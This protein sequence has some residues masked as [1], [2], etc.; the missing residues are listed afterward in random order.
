MPVIAFA[1]TKGGV[2]KTTGAINVAC[3]LHRR[4]MRTLLVDC[5]HT[6][7]GTSTFGAFAAHQSR[8]VPTVTSAPHVRYVPKMSAD[9]EWTVVDVR[10]AVKE[11]TGELDDKLFSTTLWVADFVVVSVLPS[12]IDVSN[13]TPTLQLMRRAQVAKPSLQIGVFLNTYDNTCE[14]EHAEQWL[15]EELSEAGEGC[16]LLPRW[17]RLKDFKRAFRFGKGVTQY[18][19]KSTAAS[20]V[21]QLTEEIIRNVEANATD[22]TAAAAS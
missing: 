14:S 1:H 7:R 17:H 20:Q 6:T 8:D 21:R 22:V 3:E 19:P 2:G 16:I 13:M 5:D 4:G 9:Y 10:P 11:A 18:R 12:P 15:K